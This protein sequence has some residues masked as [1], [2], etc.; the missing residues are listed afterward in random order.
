MAWPWTGLT[1]RMCCRF[2]PCSRACCSTAS[3]RPRPAPT[4]TSCRCAST[5][6]RGA[7]RRQL[8]GRART[9]RRAAQ[10]VS[11]GGPGAAGAVDR[12][13]GST[14]TAGAAGRRRGYPAHC[15]SG[16]HPRLRPG[17]RTLA[18]PGAGA[19]GRRALPVDLHQPPHPHGWLEQRPTAGRGVATLCRR[20]TAGECGQVRRL[21]GLAAT[22]RPGLDEV[23]WRG[24]LQA[25]EAPTLLG[26]ALPARRARRVSASWSMA[27]TKPSANA[28]RRSP[29]PNR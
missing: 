14:A 13:R 7:L 17:P 28:W 1:S 20:P 3:T 15:R 8:A 4:S 12:P 19:P 10:P 21:P 27:W 29:G 2:R 5:A 23:F 25:L 11:L 22:A 9:P 24:Q 16:A 26:E 6:G 18:A